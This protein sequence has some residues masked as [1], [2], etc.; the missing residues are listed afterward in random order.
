[1]RFSRAYQYTADFEARQSGF[2][3]AV[4]ARAVL[5]VATATKAALVKVARDFIKSLRPARPVSKPVQLVLDWS[6]IA[7]NS[8]VFCHQEV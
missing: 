1:M 8:N 5:E 3:F 6:A 7:T 4:V 2:D